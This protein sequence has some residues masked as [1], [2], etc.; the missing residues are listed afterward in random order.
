LKRI[1]RSLQ[2]EE[3][4]ILLAY[5]GSTAPWQ[6][7]SLMEQFLVPLLEKDTR[8]KVLFL[9][10]RTE[11]IDRLEKRFPGKIIQ[12]WLEHREVL[13]YLSRA[14][15][16]ILLREGSVTNRVASPTKFAEYLYA[17]LG[18]LISEKLGDFTEFVEVNKCGFVIDQKV[19][20]LPPLKAINDEQR[21][22]NRSLAIKY[23]TKEAVDNEKAY[24]EL[25]NFMSNKKSYL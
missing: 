8:V 25:M 13:H 10:K 6:S 22:S 12:K 9:S 14:D 17:G 24:L 5:A 19:L 15:Y 1:R 20:V 23:F 16:G 3:T 11:D 18:V 7:F 21:R 4:D 2:V